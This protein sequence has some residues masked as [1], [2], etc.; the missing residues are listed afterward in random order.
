MENPVHLTPA[1][2]HTPLSDV[3]PNSSPTK[4]RT[5]PT[6]KPASSLKE[7]QQPFSFEQK[8]KPARRACGGRSLT[9]NASSGVPSAYDWLTSPEVSLEEV[10][11]SWEAVGQLSSLYNKAVDKRTP[12]AGEQDLLRPSKIPRL[13]PQQLRPPPTGA[14]VPQQ[15]AAALAHLVAISGSGRLVTPAKPELR[16]PG[17]QPPHAPTPAPSPAPS[18]ELTGSAWRLRAFNP[19]FQGFS[20]S[21]SRM[22]SPVSSGAPSLC[23]AG[24]TCTPR[25][26]VPPSAD[27]PTSRTPP[28]DEVEP[29]PADEYPRSF[30]I[31]RSN[32]MDSVA[33]VL[34]LSPIM[35][36]PSPERE[37]PAAADEG[38][39]DAFSLVDARSYLR[40]AF[41]PTPE[42]SAKLAR[43]LDLADAADPK[44]EPEGGFASPIEPAVK[45]ALQQ[46]RAAPA[47]TPPVKPAASHSQAAP[48]QAR[49]VYG[50][51]QS[52]A[53]PQLASHPISGADTPGWSDW[54]APA[55]LTPVMRQMRDQAAK[56]KV[57]KPHG[58]SLSFPAVLSVVVQLLVLSAA[59]GFAAFG[60]LPLTGLDTYGAS[61][62]AQLH[63]AAS[64]MAVFPLW[65]APEHAAHVTRRSA[66]LLAH[67]LDGIQA[68]LASA[69][70][71]AAAFTNKLITSKPLVPSPDALTPKL[72]SM[73]QPSVDS[74]AAAFRSIPSSHPAVQIDQDYGRFRTKLAKLPP[75]PETIRQAALA[76]QQ[77][78]AQDDAATIVAGD[79]PPA[80]VPQEANSI[81][82]LVS[83][84]GPEHI[85][86]AG[87]A[88]QAPD[89]QAAVAEVPLDMS[90]SADFSN[91]PE[92]VTLVKVP[93]P[94]R[95]TSFLSTRATNLW[96]L[97]ADLFMAADAALEGAL[98][99][100]PAVTK[101]LSPET[102][103]VAVATALG[104][105]WG[106]VLGASTTILGVIIWAVSTWA[107]SHTALEEP[108]HDSS[109]VPAPK[110]QSKRPTCA[111]SP[112]P[113]D[114]DDSPVAQAK[115]LQR[116]T[117]PEPRVRA[118]PSYHLT[119]SAT[120][121][122]APA[123]P[124]DY[125]AA[126]A[127]TPRAR[128]RYNLRRQSAV[129][130]LGPAASELSARSQ[131]VST[132]RQRSRATRTGP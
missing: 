5:S 24:Y 116:D 103:E 30:P 118:Q 121:E 81:D 55:P 79:G 32:S 97:H 17:L 22:S 123:G 111:A 99:R 43:V 129:E 3:S 59:A 47:I 94:E 49:T 125:E 60:G 9:P 25:F 114:A 69:S 45:P 67:T 26:G 70:Q 56:T 120:K 98:Q 62:A 51:R 14:S 8:A 131:S 86:Q 126:A 48:E 53:S 73:A 75:I 74:I 104:M 95:L 84:S 21:S 52:S 90:Q 128:S 19:A 64:T 112:T 54:E 76:Q 71:Q 35:E 88:D 44:Q 41:G 89:E 80:A 130:E 31:Q 2:T 106:C 82:S 38:P 108:Q 23:A 93:V 1:T 96:T 122:L 6:K 12:A 107:R 28:A 100:V 11:R 77:D 102:L 34:V 113:D 40:M 58:P 91:M 101:A 85:E 127:P 92:P 78:A 20:P 50:K 65:A 68:S 37:T 39:G 132:T 13:A 72:A 109:P 83:E 7:N 66:E 15:A 29:S 42:P 119:A 36:P 18:E 87:A 117:T 27:S 63:D 16:A 110:T 33:S 57:K 61:E 115:E 46:T 105:V 124:A 10:Q 4:K